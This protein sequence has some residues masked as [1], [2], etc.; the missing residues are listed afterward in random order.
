M[1][2]YRELVLEKICPTCEF[3]N[4]PTIPFCVECGDSLTSTFP[5]ERVEAEVKIVCKDCNAEIGE[6]V[7]RCPDCD[8]VLTDAEDKYWQEFSCAEESIEATG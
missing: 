6:G 3:G 1:A 5:T 4:Q 2:D 8:C 7:F